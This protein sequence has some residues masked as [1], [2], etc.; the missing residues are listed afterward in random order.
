ML[1]GLS[2]RGVDLSGYTQGAKGGYAKLSGGERGCG[3]MVITFMSPVEETPIFE[4]YVFAK[5]LSEKG[6]EFWALIE[7]PDA[8]DRQF[9][10][11]LQR[12]FK[13]GVKYQFS[14]G[15]CIGSY[16]SSKGRIAIYK[17]LQGCPKNQYV[18][19]K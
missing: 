3:M 1:C 17:P 2:L 4:Q 18:E 13:R 8:K 15:L 16:E 14:W 7:F 11:F 12:R 10:K 6:N 19:N 5:L 9:L